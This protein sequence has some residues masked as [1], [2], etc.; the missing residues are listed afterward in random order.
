[1]FECLVQG[2]KLLERIRR[3]RRVRGSGLVG[4]SVLTG[5]L[6]SH[7]VQDKGR[8]S[9]FP[10]LITIYITVRKHPRKST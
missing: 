10:V 9:V 6:L 8:H 3:I 4:G 1:M 5:V 7:S 2:V